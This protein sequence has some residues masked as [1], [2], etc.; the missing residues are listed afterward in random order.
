MINVDSLPLFAQQ[1]H[2]QILSPLNH[3]ASCFTIASCP[4]FSFVAA[5]E[6]SVVPERREEHLLREIYLERS[7]SPLPQH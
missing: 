6:T 4:C 2:V 1:G 7:D 3:V 5:L